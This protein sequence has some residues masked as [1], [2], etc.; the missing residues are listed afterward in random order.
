MKIL[1]PITSLAPSL[2]TPPSSGSSNCC[3][4]SILINSPTLLTKTNQPTKQTCTPE[5]MGPK[6]S[7]EYSI[8]QNQNTYSSQL[9]VGHFPG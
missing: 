7:S 1:D 9:Y 3:Y 4:F 8:Q 5:Q 6:T 2:G